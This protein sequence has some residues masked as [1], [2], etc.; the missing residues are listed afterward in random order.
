MTAKFEPAASNITVNCIGDIDYTVSGN[1]VTVDH[2]VACKVGYLDG[3]AYK[4]ITAVANGDGTYSFTAPAGVTE[5]LLVVKGDA[6]GDGYI[7]KADSTRI[8]AVFNNKTTLSA[9]AL[10]AANVNSDDAIT[11]ADST[12]VKAVFNG[13]TSLDW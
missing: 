13:K 9:T 12:R 10:F 7:T 3:T 6:N 11:K 5:V 4:A 8:K 2:E 1:V